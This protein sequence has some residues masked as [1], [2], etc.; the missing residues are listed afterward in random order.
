MKA[1]DSHS[2]LSIA[3]LLNRHRF[4]NDE[5]ER[6]YR[7]YTYKLQHSSVSCD[8]LIFIINYLHSFYQM[9]F[10]F[11]VGFKCCWAICH[12]YLCFGYNKSG[13]CTCTISTEHIPW[14]PLPAVRVVAG[15]P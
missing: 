13:L 2:K 8:F 15:I 7:R 9:C 3:R 6:L 1:M 4:E 14:C 11:L 10:I 5:L 12:P